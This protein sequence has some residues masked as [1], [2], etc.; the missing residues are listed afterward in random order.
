[1]PAAKQCVILNFNCQEIL[2]LSVDALQHDGVHVIVVDNGS[3]DGSVEFLK[4]CQTDLKVILDG[5]NLG[6]SVAK[7]KGLAVANPDC[8][9]LLLDSDVLYAKGSYDYLRDLL[10]RYECDSVGFDPDFCAADWSETW[11]GQRAFD[12]ATV[13]RICIATPGYGLFRAGVLSSVRFD[14]QFGTGWGFED[15]DLY[16]QLLRN[17]FSRFMVAKWRF[18]HQRRSSLLNL[19]IRDQQIRLSDRKTYFENKWS[20]E[21]EYQS[22]LAAVGIRA[23]LAQSGLK[24]YAL[25]IDAK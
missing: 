7:N 21:P 13:S 10:N 16:L 9:V 19:A 8:D 2:Q 22:Y 24:R 1:M 18:Y 17:G 6:I 20:G 11:Y 14:E 23:V 5:A 15:V 12:L 4:L 3:D 25:S